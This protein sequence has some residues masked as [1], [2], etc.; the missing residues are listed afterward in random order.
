[1]PLHHLSRALPCLPLLQIEQE[2]A[3]PANLASSVMFD[4]VM[5]C[6]RTA[7]TNDKD[8]VRLAMLFTLRF[9]ADTMRVRQMM[10]YLVTAGVRDR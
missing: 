1:M 7:S 4:E 9:E 6:V 2:L 8:K 5:R 10:D 3:N